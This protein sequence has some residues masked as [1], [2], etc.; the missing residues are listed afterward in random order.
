MKAQFLNEIEFN[1]DKPPYER[2]KSTKGISRPSIPNPQKSGYGGGLSDEEKERII[3]HEDKIRNLN[4]EIYDFEY[5]IE[6]FQDEIDNLNTSGFDEMELEGFYS[7]VIR[8]H[9]TNVLD[10]LNT[11]YSDEEKLKHL[12]RVFPGNDTG[13]EEYEYLLRNYNYYHPEEVD[14]SK[15]IEEIN[16]KIKKLENQKEQ[17]EKTKD[18]L[19]TKIYNIENY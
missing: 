1:F 4:D 7:D 18:K 5:E 17:K 2:Y 9:G 3:K 6:R 10:V 14:N 13:P 12:D 19:E 15:K 11:G 16:Q 8:D